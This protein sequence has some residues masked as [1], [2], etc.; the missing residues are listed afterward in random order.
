MSKSVRVAAAQLAPVFFDR[1]RTTEKACEAIVEAGRGGA[2]LVAFPETFI[3]GYPYF[4]LFL[5]P[6]GINAY[7]QRLYEES[8]VLGSE[9]T[10]ALCAAARDAGCMVVMGMNEREGGTL[11]NSQLFISA[12]GQ[13]LGNRRKLVPT[14]HERMVWG[15]G[16]GSDIQLHDTDIGKVGALICY[17]HTNPLFRYAVQAQGEQIHIANWPGGMSGINDII[18][19]AVR[20]YAFEGQTFVINVTSVLTEEAIGGLDDELAANL[21]P[22]GGYSSIVSPRGKLLAGPLED[23]EGILY[24]DLDFAEIDRVKSI[25]DGA[26]HYARPDVVTLNLERKKRRPL[27]IDD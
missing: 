11:Y 6:T 23:A 7:M 3:P 26:G 27:Q 1:A 19:A 21:S 4:A 25:V 18:D 5:P 14:S 22:G 17:E 8:V 24:A 2:R 10:D 16:D 20:H 15:R 9:A 12:D 13:I